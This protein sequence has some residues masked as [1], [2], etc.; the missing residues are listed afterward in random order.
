MDV[1]LIKRRI[2]ESIPGARADVV[3]QAGGNHIAAT[4]VAESFAGKTRMQRHQMIYSLF[5]SEM[6]T[7]E[8]HALTLKTFTPREHAEASKE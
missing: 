2:E 4:I 6:A 7:E 8:I 5:K 1:E 3:D